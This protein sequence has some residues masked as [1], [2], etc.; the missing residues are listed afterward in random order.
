M[1][2]YQTVNDV[3]IHLFSW[4]IY[5]NNVDG[6]TEFLRGFTVLFLDSVWQFFFEYDIGYNG[7][8]NDDVHGEHH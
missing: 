4:G 1:L 6:E 7:Y 8:T 3:H 2:K 5:E